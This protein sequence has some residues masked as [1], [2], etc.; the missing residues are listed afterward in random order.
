MLGWSSWSSAGTHVSL[1]EF[2]APLYEHV[3]FMLANLQCLGID[4]PYLDLACRG[5]GYMCRAQTAHACAAVV[6]PVVP[7]TGSAAPLR[8]LDLPYRCLDLPYRCL[9]LPYRLLDLPDRWLDLPDRWLDLPGRW[10]YL[11]GRW[12]DLPCRS[13]DLPCC[14]LYLPWR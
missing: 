3:L 14:R 13:L 4:M 8:W 1:I 6:E 7:L 12:L 5:L 11:P 10:L 9:D 2:N